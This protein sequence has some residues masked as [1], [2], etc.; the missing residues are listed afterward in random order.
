MRAIPTSTRH[1]RHAASGVADC[2][3]A[4]RCPP[5][6]RARAH[7]R[8]ACWVHL[9]RPATQLRTRTSALTPLACAPPQVEQLLHVESD[10]MM[11]HNWKARCPRQLQCM[12]LLFRAHALRRVRFDGDEIPFG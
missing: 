7:Y 10:Y 2:A 1:A 11:Q 6:A 3:L 8:A 5:H 9:Q 12:Q 4:V